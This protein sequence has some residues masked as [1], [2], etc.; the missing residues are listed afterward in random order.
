M[1]KYFSLFHTVSIILSTVFS[2]PLAYISSFI[3]V[4]HKFGLL[5]IFILVLSF[6]IA[7]TKHLMMC[8]RETYP[9]LEIL[10]LNKTI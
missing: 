7:V 6:L 9:P 10:S 4:I 1:D 5:I 3:H 8:H 2:L